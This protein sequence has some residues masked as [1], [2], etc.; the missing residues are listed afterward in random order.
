ML[1]RNEL[2]KALDKLRIKRASVESQI[3]SCPEGRL[4][5]TAHR[6]KLLYYQIPEGATVKEKIRI[7]D[8][9]IIVDFM[10]KLFLQG[11]LKLLDENIGLLENMLSSYQNVT[12]ANIINH[13]KPRDAKLLSKLPNESNNIIHSD[14]ITIGPAYNPLVIPKDQYDRI[15]SR[16]E[17]ANGAYYDNPFR[18]EDRDKKTSRGLY[19]RSKS[20]LLIAEKLYEY[21]IPFRYEAEVRCR[22]RK[23]YQGFKEEYPDFTFLDAQDLP[24]YLEYCGLMDD[25]DY[26]GRH[27][28]KRSV[29]DES[30]IN[31]WTNI[32]YMYEENNEID[33]E[34][35]EAIIRLKIIPRL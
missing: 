22:D 20:E 6:G 8:V 35:V 25:P 15:R 2:E 30:G 9:H 17:W 27:K 10:K 31:E 7:K 32:I 26:V 11:E 33:M 5:H 34:Y 12:K 13:L 19:V 1:V 24:F 23:G 14:T 18:P 4:F 3:N 21:G 29:Y 16:N 28:Y